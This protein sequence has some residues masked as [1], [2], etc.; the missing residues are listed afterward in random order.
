MLAEM[1]RLSLEDGP[2]MQVHPG[3]VRNQSGSIFARHGRD[4]GPGIPSRTEYVH[5]LKPLLDRFGNESG[6][7]SVSRRSRRHPSPG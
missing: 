3:A 7:T 5:A 6:L 1:A 4:M 2:V